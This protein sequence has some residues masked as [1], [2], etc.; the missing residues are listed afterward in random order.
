MKRKLAFLMAFAALTGC[1][2]TRGSDG[3]K[4]PPGLTD[5]HLKPCPASP[6][7]ISTEY[8]DDAA[9]YA[10]PVKMAITP[11]TAALVKE[12][13]ESIGGK[14]VEERDNYLAFTFTSLVFRF[15]DDFE[16]RLDPDDNLLHIRSASRVGYSDLGVN[17]RRVKRFKEALREG[18]RTQP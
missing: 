10:E 16:V 3:D 15:V 2:G 17:G 1:A 13:A 6:N 18:S 7:C 14:L 5:G 12:A 9:H 11:D 4:P 8:P